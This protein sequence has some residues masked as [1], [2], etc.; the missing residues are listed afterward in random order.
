MSALPESQNVEWKLEVWSPGELPPPLTPEALY[1]PHSSMLRNPLLAQAFYF[2]GVI[3]RWGT[4]TTR[5]VRLCR[6]QGLPDPEFANWLGGVRVVFSKDPY[7]PE[8]LRAMG[9][10]ERQLNAIMNTKE[11]GRITNE[12][13][14]KIAGVSKPTATRDLEMLVSEGLLEKV[15]T[16]GR[17][18]YYVLRARK[19]IKGLSM[20][21]KTAQRGTKGASKGQNDVDR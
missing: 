13:Y 20:D 10:S 8:R 7:T 19:G 18:V 15:G 3:E 6:E 11:Q 2:A 9:L 5:I 16:T 17:G 4:G 1:G 21:S 12:Q 14:Q